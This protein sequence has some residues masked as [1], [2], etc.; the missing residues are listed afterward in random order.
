MRDW[1]SMSV[2][3]V[4]EQVFLELDA[5][6]YYDLCREKAKNE[7]D[8]I[9]RKR[10]LNVAIACKMNLRDFTFEDLTTKMFFAYSKGMKKIV[11][12][13][14]NLL[15]ECI[16][17]KDNF[18]R[19]LHDNFVSF[20]DGIVANKELGLLVEFN[21][22]ATQQSIKKDWKDV[23]TKKV[24]SAYLSLIQ[25]GITYFYDDLKEY[26]IYYD[27]K[28][29][30]FATIS[31]KYPMIDWCTEEITFQATKRYRE[32]G[33]IDSDKLLK[34][35]LRK[36]RKY[37]MNPQNMSDIENIFNSANNYGN[38]LMAMLYYMN[39]NTK[40]FIPQCDEI[41]AVDFE[42]PRVWYE[43]EY[44][45]E[46]LKRRNFALPPETVK[47]TLRYANGVKEIWYREVIKDGK[48]VVLYRLV[49]ERKNDVLR[50]YFEETEAKFT[51]V[52]GYYIP[53]EKFF[54]G[55]YGT[56]SKRDDNDSV[57]KLADALENCVLENYF[58]LTVRRTEEEKTHK[59]YSFPLIAEEYEN[60]DK[61]PRWNN[62]P[63]VSFSIISNDKKEDLGNKSKRQG[64][65]KYKQGIY[66][67]DDVN[68]ACFMRRLPSGYKV[69]EEAKM[70][71]EKYGYELEEGYTFVVP[72]ERKQR[73]IK[74]IGEE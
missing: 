40:E 63:I 59:K 56:T 36:F 45:K 12:F 21:N 47:A 41:G 66:E 70:N 71:A 42:F 10:T 46:R 68:I 37:G 18:Y 32:K 55:Y 64:N 58:L 34:E 73:H 1:K 3:E 67:Y 15:Y 2:E 38:M 9:I 39:E 5:V 43:T 11:S 27:D 74:M 54:Y 23:K 50:K 57:H 25:Q 61:V 52:V 4:A 22:L 60:V 31:D 62:Q 14:E 28:T 30:S 35:S 44:Y 6:T 13:F 69:S 51:D 33:K 26:P 8:F 19:T 16:E 53:S 29:D 20:R 24:F 17:D 65:K 72:F 48:I 49:A 7:S